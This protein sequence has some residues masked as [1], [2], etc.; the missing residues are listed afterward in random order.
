MDVFDLENVGNYIPGGMSFG[1]GIKVIKEVVQKNEILGFD[2]CE[3]C[4]RKED[5]TSIT[6]AK[7]LYKILGYME[8][9][10]E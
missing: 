5:R 1:E 9:Y 4:L 3:V 7:L 6:A 8:K 2:I 10:K